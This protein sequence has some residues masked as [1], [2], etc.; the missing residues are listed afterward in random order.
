MDKEND[1]LGDSPERFE[2]SYVSQTV[3]SVSRKVIGEPRESLS[4]IKDT[5]MYQM[6]KKPSFAKFLD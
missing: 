2:R 6:N 3:K 5:S 4:P 1:N